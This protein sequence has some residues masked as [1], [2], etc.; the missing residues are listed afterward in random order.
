M[1]RK[2][3]KKPAKRHS[4]AKVAKK[5]TAPIVTAPTIWRSVLSM[6]GGEQVT[7]NFPTEE[8]KEEAM[9]RLTSNTESFQMPS[10]NVYVR[11]T[12]ISAI[13]D[14][15]QIMLPTSQT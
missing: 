11:P 14:V 6:A 4:R 3:A 15:G 2:V 7:V 9:G 5:I 8:D 10:K 1:A 12:H 13:R